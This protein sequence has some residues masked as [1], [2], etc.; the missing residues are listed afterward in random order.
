[1]IT[2][3]RHLG[4]RTGSISYVIDMIGEGAQKKRLVSGQVRPGH[5]KGYPVLFTDYE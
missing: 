3:E 4:T 2:I 5:V 1:M